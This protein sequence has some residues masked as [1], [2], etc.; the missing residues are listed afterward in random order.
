MFA[1]NGATLKL[2]NDLDHTGQV[3]GDDKNNLIPDLDSTGP[4]GERRRNPNE[5]MIL[6]IGPDGVFKHP[7]RFFATHYESHRDTFFDQV[8]ETSPVSVTRTT[9]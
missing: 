7:V 3:Q 8:N 4:L 5:M 9:S 2:V 1:G 6:Q